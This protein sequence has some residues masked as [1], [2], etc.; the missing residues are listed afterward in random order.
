[1]GFDCCVVLRREV[2]DAKKGV[3]DAKSG[4]IWKIGLVPSHTITHQRLIGYYEAVETQGGE[5]PVE[6]WKVPGSVKKVLG[7]KILYEE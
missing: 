4:A 2:D 5:P 6:G 3:D 7:L 1:M